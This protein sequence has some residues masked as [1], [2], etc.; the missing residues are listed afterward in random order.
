MYYC[1]ICS[2]I[3]HQLENDV[4]VFENGFYVDPLF[5]G[6]LHLGMC[7]KE[8]GIRDEDPN[9]RYAITDVKEKLKELKNDLPVHDYIAKL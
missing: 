9:M 1:I 7:N 4:R 2:E 3:H 5:G 6:K 8:S